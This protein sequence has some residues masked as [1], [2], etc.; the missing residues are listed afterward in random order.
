MFSISSYSDICLNGCFF[1]FVMKD[2]KI[3]CSIFRITAK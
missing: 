2:V 1:L 3:I